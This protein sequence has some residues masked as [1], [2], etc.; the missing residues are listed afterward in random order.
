MNVCCALATR[1]LLL[2]VGPCIALVAAD[3]QA[4]HAEEISYGAELTLS[5]TA[6]ETA[7]LTKA[8]GEDE[9]I[10]AYV[11]DLALSN[12]VVHLEG[13]TA[14]F[15]FEPSR[16]VWK[17]LAAHRDRLLLTDVSLTVGVEREKP[18]PEKDTLHVTFVTRW[19]LGAYMSEEGVIGPR[20]EN[21]P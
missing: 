10:V 1:S 7:S 12:V 8:E 21:G 5:L 18:L 19:V 2:V 17:Q 3:A 16:E 6:A 13:T 11:D 14:R 15:A 20:A 9:K 4:H